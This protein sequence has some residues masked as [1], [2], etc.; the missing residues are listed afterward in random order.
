[1]ERTSPYKH[2]IYSRKILQGR[3]LNIWEKV[4]I[5][6]NS[7]AIDVDIIRLNAVITASARI[8]QKN[9]TGKDENSTDKIIVPNHDY[10][11]GKDK[12]AECIETTERCETKAAARG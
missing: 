11:L 2:H 1:M 7:D 5:S 8:L 6:R 3:L 4:E 12:V 10:F 9:F